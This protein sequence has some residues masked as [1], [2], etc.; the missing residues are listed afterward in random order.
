M[1]PSADRELPFTS[2]IDSRSPSWSWGEANLLVR[3]RAS[4][5][6]TVR[7]CFE[8]SQCPR[9][10]WQSGFADQRQQCAFATSARLTATVRSREHLPQHLNWRRVEEETAPR[11]IECP[12]P[13]SDVPPDPRSRTSMTSWHTSPTPSPLC[14]AARDPSATSRSPRTRNLSSAKDSRHEIPSIRRSISH[15]S[16]GSR[17][18]RHAFDDEKDAPPARRIP[19]T[20][21]L[22]RLEAAGDIA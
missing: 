4:A 21:T 18:V 13:F 17:T 22:H 9:V 12:L 3:H 16:G 8:N 20:Q 6:Q 19:R 10:G 7:N 1:A 11:P 14:A 15:P 2:A 5:Q